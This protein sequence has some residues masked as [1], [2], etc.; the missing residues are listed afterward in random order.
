MSAMDFD[1]LQ[2]LLQEVGAPYQLEGLNDAG[3]RLRLSV[4]NAYIRPGG[5]IS[6]PTLM[7]LADGTAWSAL[8]ARIGPVVSAVS[9]SLHIDFLRRPKP[10]DVV[11]EGRILRLGRSLAVID[12]AIRPETE[13]ELLAAARVTYAIPTEDGGS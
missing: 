5:T 10:Q 1:A 8:L 12:V 7:T 4:A 9:T 13:E 6:G 2:A 11:A 3:V